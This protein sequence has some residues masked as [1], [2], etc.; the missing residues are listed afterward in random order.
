MQISRKLKTFSGLFI[1]CLKSTLN[2]GYFGRKDQSLSLSITEIFNCG[3][4]SYL[5]VQKAI[6]HTT[7]RHSTCQR[8]LKTAG[9]SMEK[10]SYHS[11][12]SLG[13]RAK[14]K[15]RPGQI[16][17]LRTVFQHIDC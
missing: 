1:A 8:V 7:F 11:S 10:A 15:V 3:K 6:F 2:L 12:I 13:K 5:N 14:N 4:G 16:Q 17:I 9:K